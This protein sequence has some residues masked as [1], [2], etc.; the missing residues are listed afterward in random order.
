MT[1]GCWEPLIARTSPAAHDKYKEVVMSIETNKALQR[2]MEE[3]LTQHNLDVL[4]E[5]F[6]VDYVELEP[7]PG[8]ERASRG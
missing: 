2:R 6:H 4:D 7:P 3:A 1:G 5:I 8:M